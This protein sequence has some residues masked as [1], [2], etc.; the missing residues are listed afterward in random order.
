MM[1]RLQ[2]SLLAA[3]PLC[4]AKSLAFSIHEDLQAFPQVW[5]A[6]EL[7]HMTRTNADAIAV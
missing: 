1:R 3:L 7:M 2:L 6:L 5:I 4:R